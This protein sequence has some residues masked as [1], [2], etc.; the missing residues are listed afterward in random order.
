MSDILFEKLPTVA[1][2]GK[3]RFGNYRSV[4]YMDIVDRTL[5]RAE[6]LSKEIAGQST[7]FGS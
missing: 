3:L 6:A 5:E 1:N 2:Q 7:E 4:S